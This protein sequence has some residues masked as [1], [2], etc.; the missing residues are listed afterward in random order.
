MMFTGKPTVT[1]TESTGTVSATDVAAEAEKVK[2]DAI[3]FFP[4]LKLGVG[5]TF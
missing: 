3:D 2:K 4:I 1:L 5:Y